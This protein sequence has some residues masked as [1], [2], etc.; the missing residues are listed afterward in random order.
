MKWKTPVSEESTRTELKQISARA[1]ELQQ[2]LTQRRPIDSAVDVPQS[3]QCA[4]CSHQSVQPTDSTCSEDSAERLGSK[5]QYS[6]DTSGKSV[7]GAKCETRRHS[8]S[9]YSFA[10]PFIG[11]L[12]GETLLTI[13]DSHHVIVLG[14]GEVAMLTDHQERAA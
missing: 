11:L 3:A 5:D 9:L 7:P 14:L 12:A 1:A 2:M 4:W 6:D 8:L 13:C 10:D